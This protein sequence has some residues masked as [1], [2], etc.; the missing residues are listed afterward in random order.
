MREGPALPACEAACRERLGLGPGDDLPGPWL[1]GIALTVSP[2]PP[3]AA[4]RSA[5]RAAARVLGS[6]W[7][8]S[9]RLVPSGP[10]AFDLVPR[11]PP[12]WS[13]GSAWELARRLAAQRGV[14][15]AEPEFVLFVANGEALA[16]P[17]ASGECEPPGERHLPATDPPAF[18]WAL[19]MVRARD[20]WATARGEGVAV[21][22]PDTGWLAH[23]E[24]LPLGEGGPVDTA[25][26]RDFVADDDDARAEL[27]DDDPFPGGP[28]HGTATASVIASPEGPQGG[29]YAGFVTGIAPGASLVPLRVGLGVVHFSTRRLRK[30]LAYAAALP[31]PRGGGPAPGGPLPVV[32]LSL[33]A[34]FP[35][36]SLERSVAEAVAR[37]LV[38][39]AAAGNAVPFGAVVWPARLPGVIAVAA[40]NA[41]RAPWRPSSRGPRVD[42]TAPGESVWRAHVVARRDEL[43]WCVGRSSGTSYATALVAGAC[44]LW[45]S[46]HGPA[47]LRERYGGGLGEAFRAVLRASASSDHRLPAGQFGAGLLDAAALLETP[48]PD[49]REVEAARRAREAAL[50]AGARAA[51]RGRE[52]GRAATPPP[53][54]VAI[55]AG[56]LPGLPPA[57]LRRGVAALLPAGGRSL[58]DT[59]DAVGDELAFA[60]AIRPHLLRRLGA[61]CRRAAGAPLRERRAAFAGLRRRLAAADVSDSLA[62]ALGD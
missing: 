13:C 20:A 36:R 58:E 28:G 53:R 50:P 30:A 7:R 25:R 44:A 33:G 55:L 31:A 22:H 35:S 48:L 47:R 38:L 62:A 11:P 52:R 51:S 17:P 59:L 37:G 8:R 39:V 15:G 6:A 49:P 46:H 29:G 2:R 21:A 24:L 23:P 42:V 27:G 5:E 1:E 18:E 56:L 60:L 45:L 54:P 9:W 43:R 41:R 19:E 14:E 34:P 16:E 61:C 3:A 10:A 12:G 40:A 4:R 57:E 26:D 32:S